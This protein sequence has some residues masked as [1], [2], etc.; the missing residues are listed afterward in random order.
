MTTKNLGPP[1]IQIVWTPAKCQRC[2]L[3]AATW[4]FESLPLF[5]HY[6]TPG[7]RDQAKMSHCDDCMNSVARDYDEPF[8]CELFEVVEAIED[9]AHAVVIEW[10]PT[11]CRSCQKRPAVLV[12]DDSSFTHEDAFA[13]AS[14]ATECGD[15]CGV[16]PCLERTL[17]D[18]LW[19]LHETPA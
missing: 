9:L 18:T 6:D 8:T 17:V 1:A 19:Q 3:N 2:K 10:S 5:G 7:L 13:C 11:M 12:N 14:C 15:C 4:S 16:Y